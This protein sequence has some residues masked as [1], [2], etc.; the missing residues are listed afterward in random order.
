MQWIIYPR[1]AE[2]CALMTRIRNKIVAFYEGDIDRRTLSR[3]L[4]Q[5]IPG[6]MVP[7]VFMQ[8][9]KMPLTK[10]G[11]IDRKELSERYQKR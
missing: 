6:F 10:N 4:L 8:I 5:H 3:S 9:E 2:V 7:N 11:K 1:S